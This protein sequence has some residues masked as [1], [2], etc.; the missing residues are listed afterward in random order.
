MDSQF[1]FFDSSFSILFDVDVLVSSFIVLRLTSVMT[2]FLSKKKVI[3]KWIN[4]NR[5]NEFNE[6]Y[7]KKQKFDIEY[8]A[9]LL[10]FTKFYFPKNRIIGCKREYKHF[11]NN[12]MIIFK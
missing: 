7:F 4:E 12:K 8:H 3:Q 6:Y 10:L 2:E 9:K 11:L 5:K 1:L